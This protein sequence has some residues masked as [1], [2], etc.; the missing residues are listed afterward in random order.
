MH[1][2]LTGERY[3][4]SHYNAGRT[5]LPGSVQSPP[6]N[7]LRRVNT[8]LKI[9]L[10]PICGVD[11]HYLHACVSDPRIF[12]GEPPRFDINFHHASFIRLLIVLS[13]P[14]QTC[15]PKRPTI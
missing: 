8:F 12:A 15:P 9:S 4:F 14:W 2:S 7:R 11:S 10:R 5:I 3:T 13:E 6:S 1:Y